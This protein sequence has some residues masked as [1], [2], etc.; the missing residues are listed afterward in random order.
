VKHIAVDLLDPSQT[1]AALSG[2]GAVTH[3]FYA[4]YQN[5][6]T[7]AELVAPNLAMLVNT[8]DAIE[9]VAPGLEHVSLMQGY[10]TRKP[11]LSDPPIG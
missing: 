9:P 3:V 11:S 1:A 7:W 6:P 10:K 8:L 4:A 5:R 2:L